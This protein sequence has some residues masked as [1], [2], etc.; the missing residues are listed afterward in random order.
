MDNYQMALNIFK[1]S[2]VN[3]DLICLIGMNRKSRTYDKPYYVLYKTLRMFLDGKEDAE[4]LLESAKKIKIYQVFYGE[5]C[6]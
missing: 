2:K 4:T 6:F 1:E 5:I 3:E